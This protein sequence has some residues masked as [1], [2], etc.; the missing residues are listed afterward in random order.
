M[1]K[2]SM[3][4]YRTLDRLEKEVNINHFTEKAHREFESYAYAANAGA[5]SEE[6]AWSWFR[7]LV[8]DNMQV[9][10]SEYTA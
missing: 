6:A 2:K 1:L 4:T 8:A 3:L 7:H 5:E 9:L 10:L